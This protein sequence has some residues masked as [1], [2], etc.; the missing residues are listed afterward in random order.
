[1]IKTSEPRQ[2]PLP[3]TKQGSAPQLPGDG[4]L[5]DAMIKAATKPPKK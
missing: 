5:Q 3:G 4:G 2:K 1:M